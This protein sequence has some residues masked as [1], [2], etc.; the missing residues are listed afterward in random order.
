MPPFV[1]IVALEISNM[2]PPKHETPE[3]K[4]WVMSKHVSCQT[5]MLDGCISQFRDLYLNCMPELQNWDTF[6]TGIYYGEE[7]WEELWYTIPKSLK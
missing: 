5:Q 4:T 6:T 2:N 1:G 7:I 3:R